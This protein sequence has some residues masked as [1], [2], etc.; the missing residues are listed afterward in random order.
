MKKKELI[1]IAIL[2]F[3]SLGG[4]AL[5]YCVNASD[6]PLTVRVSRDGEVIATLPLSLDY[7]ETFSSASGSNTLVIS[8]GT[9]DIT[10]ADC[11]GQVC[12][13][14]HSISNPGE[15]I[16]CLPNKLIVEIITGDK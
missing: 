7:S 8:N 9:A 5:F 4:I 12:V 13:D 11:P 15:T 2:L 1:I 16:V 14:T 10:E 3:I 6:Q